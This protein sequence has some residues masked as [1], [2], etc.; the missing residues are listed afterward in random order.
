MKMKEKVW[1]Y[2]IFMT[3]TAENFMHKLVVLFHSFR[4]DEDVI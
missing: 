3:E 2:V 4:V 1:G